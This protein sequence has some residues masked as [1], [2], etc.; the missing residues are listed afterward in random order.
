M[1]LKALPN[2]QLSSKAK[3]YRHH[4]SMEERCRV[5]MI[6]H[7]GLGHYCDILRASQET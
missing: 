1:P 5:M 4:Q 3:M 7:P 6:P 2:F